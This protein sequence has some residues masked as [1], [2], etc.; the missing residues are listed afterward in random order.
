MADDPY[1]PPPAGLALDFATARAAFVEA[2]A[3]AGARLA[4]IPHPLPG[5]DGAS[6]GADLAD[7]GPADAPDV[8][9]V[10][11][12]THGVEGF[13]GSALQTRWLEQRP[14]TRPDTVRV[15]FL[16]AHNPH[17]FAWVRRVNEDN[18]DLNRNFIVWSAPAPAN[19]GYDAVA[20][21]LVPTEWTEETQ[22]ATTTAILDR[23]GE[24]GFDTL[25][26]HITQGQYRHPTGVF[27]GGSGPTWS[28]DRMA[29]ICA[30]HLGDAERIAIIDLHTGL[31]EWG[32]GELIGHHA[33]DTDAHRRAVGWW[34]DVRSMVDGESVSASLV[35]DWLA[36][37]DRWLAPAEVTSAA[38]EY[39]TVDPITV[40]Q[41]LR[42]DAVLHAHGDPLGPG[43]GA[44]RAQVRTAF[45]DDDP[46]WIAAL[47]PRFVEVVD[48]ALTRLT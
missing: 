44:V 26:A 19:P 37:A 5:P 40:L 4:H 2:A 7:L 6:I 48:H 30:D 12:G 1:G 8:V 39:G 41:A 13:A 46:S 3:A 14:A 42:A 11:S 10:V 15:V 29:E 27:Y 38:L 32:H 28:Y 34:G 36:A 22:T 33:V 18:V 20:D 31:G 24:L 9:L 17:G 45:A 16:H 23:A 21:V 43:A 25:Q 47:W 35:G